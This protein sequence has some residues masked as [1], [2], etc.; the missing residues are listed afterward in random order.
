DMGA[1]TGL[2][3]NV[4]LNAFQIALEQ[5]SIDPKYAT[6]KLAAIYE[7]LEPDYMTVQ[8]EGRLI[9]LD[10]RLMEFLMLNLM[11]AMFYTRLGENVVRGGNAFSSGDFVDVL[12]HFPDTVVPERRKKRAYIS[13]ILSKN[14]VTRD[15]KYNRKLF[16]RIKH[17]QYIIN[18]Q[19]SLW[20]EDEWRSIYDLLS[21]DLL[22]YRL[23]D[24]QSYF[25]VNI[26][27]HLQKQLEHFRSQVMALC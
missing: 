3:N 14:E 25:Y 4:G 26:D 20:V 24:G 1:N 5:A 11:M 6:K 18:P 13:N 15:D 7:I 9:K 10:K 21:L 23:R 2:I 8:A 12:S 19:L 27:E 17:G 22:A 16:R